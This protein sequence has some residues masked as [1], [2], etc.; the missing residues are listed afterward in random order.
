MLIVTK[1]NKDELPAA[2]KGKSTTEL[3]QII[4]QSSKERSAIQKQILE[5]TFK[6][7][8]YIK[9]EKAKQANQSTVATLETEIEK[10][11]KEQAKRFAIA[12]KQ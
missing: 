5:L 6:R 2:L 11:I 12:I 9:A 7:Q 10:T 8:Q 4:A 3:K 1:L